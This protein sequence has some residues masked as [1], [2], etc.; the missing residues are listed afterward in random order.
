VLLAFGQHPAGAGQRTKQ[1]TASVRCSQ[2][3]WR[4]PA[5]NCGRTEASA[6]RELE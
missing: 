1:Y 2:Q 6:R 4:E 5:K 3:D